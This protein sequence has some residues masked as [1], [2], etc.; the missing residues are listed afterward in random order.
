QRDPRGYVSG[1]NPYAYARHNPVDHM[2]PSGE[3]LPIIALLVIF[4]AVVGVLYSFDDASVHPERYPGPFAWRAFFNTGAGA[5]IGGTTALGGEAVLASVGMGS[6]VAGTATVVG[7][8]VTLTPVQTFV[9][10]GTVSVVGGLAWRSGFNA[11]F[12][13]YEAPPSVGTM[14]SDY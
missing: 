13:E 3:V 9:L 12:P 4:G 2:D 5:V 7:T 6:G 1:A 14:I 11:L 8:G 10:S